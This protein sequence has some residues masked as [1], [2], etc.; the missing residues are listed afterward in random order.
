MSSDLSS[1]INVFS[2]FMD[3]KYHKKFK[4]IEEILSLPISAYKFIDEGMAILLEEYFN[5][6]NIDDIIKLD[7][8]KPLESLISLKIGD[9]ITEESDEVIFEKLGMLYYK[10]YI[11]IEEEVGLG[12]LFG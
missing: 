7:K 9:D 2:K 10:G 3:S 1:A 4:N 6:I 12:S 8:D 11:I 5:I